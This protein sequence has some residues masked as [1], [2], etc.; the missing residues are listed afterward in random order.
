LLRCW[1]PGR[2][3][4]QLARE[5]EKLAA[6]LERT[7]QNGYGENFRGWQQE[8]KIASIAV[9]IRRQQR[10]IGCLN[11]VYMAKAMT[12]E[13][14]AQN[15]SP[16]CRRSLP[17]RRTDVRRGVLPITLSIGVIAVSHCARLRYIFY[18]AILSFAAEPIMSRHPRFFA[19]TLFSASLFA[20]QAFA[21]RTLTDQLGREVTSRPRH[22]RRGAPA[23]DL[24]PAGAA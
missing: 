24:K 20:G 21:D 1:P 10:V 5:P 13:Q 23:S 7:R 11:L 8:E 14:A 9:P 3:E 4:Y 2:K 17:D 6:I 16:R 19:M 12:I 15:I 18:T 22:P